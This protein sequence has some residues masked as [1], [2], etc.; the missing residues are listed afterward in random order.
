MIGSIMLINVFILLVLRSHGTAA[1][2]NASLPN[3]PAMRAARWQDN[4][5]HYASS[6]LSQVRLISQSDKACISA[7]LKLFLFDRIL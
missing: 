2:C 3:T 7:W 5:L 6:M 4:T 1:L